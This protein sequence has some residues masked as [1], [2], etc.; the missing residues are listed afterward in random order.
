MQFAKKTGHKYNLQNIKKN[1]HDTRLWKREMLSEAAP[2]QIL[3]LHERLYVFFIY[4]FVSKS[5]MFQHSEVHDG[6]LAALLPSAVRLQGNQSAQVQLG[7]SGMRELRIRVG[8]ACCRRPGLPDV[9][10]TVLIW[11]GTHNKK[12]KKNPNTFIRAVWGEENAARDTLTD[13][14]LRGHHHLL[15]TGK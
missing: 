13:W 15:I 1:M 9:A 4:F 6:F 10:V 11:V 8:S 5:E 12:K 14:K 2:D 3:A 7:V